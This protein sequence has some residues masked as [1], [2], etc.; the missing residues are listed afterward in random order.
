MCAH[1]EKTTFSCKD[2]YCKALHIYG[3]QGNG[4]FALRF[5]MEPFTNFYINKAHTALDILFFAVFSSKIMFSVAIL[6]FKISIR[7]ERKFFSGKAS[8]KTCKLGLLDRHPLTPTYL[9]SLGSL[10]RCNFLIDSK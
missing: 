5:F 7:T 3:S 2:D 10:K 4:A 1:T 8:K 6:L 9:R